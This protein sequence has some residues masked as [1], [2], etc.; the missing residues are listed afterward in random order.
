MTW[1]AKHDLEITVKEGNHLHWRD[2][3][4]VLPHSCQESCINSW[5]EISASFKGK[6]SLGPNLKGKFSLGKRKPHSLP[7]L[8]LISKHQLGN[9]IH[10]NWESAKLQNYFF[11]SSFIAIQS[12]QCKSVSSKSNFWAI[13]PSQSVS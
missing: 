9:L 13:S 1:L 2:F 7:P 4:L 10:Q 3:L 12:F 5:T 6:F 11:L 8:Q